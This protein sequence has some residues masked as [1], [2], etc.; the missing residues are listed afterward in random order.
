MRLSDKAVFLRTQKH[1]SIIKRR[2]SEFQRQLPEL[3][4]QLPELYQ[5]CHD[6]RALEVV[7]IVLEV[8]ARALEVVARVQNPSAKLNI[9]LTDFNQVKKIQRQLPDMT[10]SCQKTEVVA[11]LESL[12]F[13][14]QLPELQ[15][16]S[17]VHFSRLSGMYLFLFNFPFNFFRLLASK[18]R[19][20]Y[21]FWGI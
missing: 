20:V 10:G 4:R 11:R 17:V 12:Y 9:F 13:Q 21:S 6:A 15:K 2:Q 3:Q 16:K 8:V 1:N 14:R 7:A 19:E 18:W 5:S